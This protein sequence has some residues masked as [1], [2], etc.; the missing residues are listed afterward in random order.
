MVNRKQIEDGEW[1]KPKLQN[2][3]F[4]CCDCGLVHTMD[5]KIEGQR[6]LF[7]AYRDPEETQAARGGS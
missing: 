1:V 7:R 4:E 5:F 6:V 3:S 2:F